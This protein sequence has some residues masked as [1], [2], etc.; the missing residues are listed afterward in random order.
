[1]INK[2]VSSS[3]LIHINKHSHVQSSL[4]Q[5]NYLNFNSSFRMA[6]ALSWHF[7]E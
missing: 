4:P 2:D 1:M 7:I 3:I 5:L 6:N